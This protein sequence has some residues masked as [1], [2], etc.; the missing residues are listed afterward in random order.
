MKVLF[1]P[2]CPGPG[3]AHAGACLSVA[4]ELA[5]RGDEAV[6][7]YGG[8]RP[9]LVRRE[10]VRIVE[11]D[12]IPLEW[13]GGHNQL[14]GFYPDVESLIRFIEGDRA[15]IEAE[16][17]DVVVIDMRLPSATAAELAGVP[18][19]TINHFLPATGYTTLTSWQ[20]RLGMLRYPRHVASRLGSIFKRDPLRVE[21]LS[22]RF[23]EA[24]RR[25]GLPPREGLPMTGDCTAFTTTPFLDPAELRVVSLDIAWREITE[26]LD[27]DFVDHCGKYLL[28][29]RMPRA[30]SHPDDLAP[31]ILGGLV[32]QPDCGRLPAP[33]QLVCKERRI[34]I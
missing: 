3:L 25:L 27:L 4:G 5:A 29:T 31:L 17:P 32:S 11:V 12:E 14:D 21:A 1:F 13:A 9:D 24:R 34:E 6:L 10:G 28:P 22:G 23:A 30:D 18:L 20:R 2:F 19:V 26:R 15:L 33:P 16:A 7:A 8:S